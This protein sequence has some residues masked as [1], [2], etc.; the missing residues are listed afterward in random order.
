[1]ARSHPEVQSNWQA[2]Q[3]QQYASQPPPP[4]AGFSSPSHAVGQNP[5]DPVPPIDQRQGFQ[6]YDLSTVDPM[7][8]L[9]AIAGC[10]LIILIQAAVECGSADAC[11]N[12]FAYTLAAGILSFLFSL[13]AMSIKMCNAELF[14]TMIPAF[15]ALLA[16]WWLFGTAVATFKAPFNETGNGFFAAW[17]CFCLSFLLAGSSWERLRA[18]MGKSLA[19]VMAGDIESKLSMAI[20]VA[21]GILLVATIVEA[22]E[23]DD[24]INT[25]DNP[26]DTWEKTTTA[27]AWGIVCG[28]GSFILLLSHTMIRMCCANNDAENA[29]GER[30]ALP[31][32]ILGLILS[33]WW[34]AGVAFLT[35]DKP[36][37]K[38]GNGYFA[39]W[40]S[41]VFSMWL[42]YEG[43]DG[44]DFYKDHEEEFDQNP[45]VQGGQPNPQMGQ[46]EMP[47][48]DT[49]YGA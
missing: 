32:W 5:N 36:F 41:F 33:V 2:E 15:G 43:Y 31:P 3:P 49:R 17:A 20:M 27:E 47:P 34:L 4:P 38:G 22:T 26:L 29:G 18:C 10:S 14:R 13:V 40:L 39:C 9:A 35:F 12:E 25:D 1:M 24:S 44:Y 11:K 6:G 46:G 23:R 28:F 48:Y 37:K 21:S 45:Q 30:C 19:K 16:I 8:C 7:A 42:T